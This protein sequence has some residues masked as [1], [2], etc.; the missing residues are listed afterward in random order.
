[1]S[2]SLW[3]GYDRHFVGTN[4]H[5]VMCGDLP[6]CSSKIEPVSLRKCPHL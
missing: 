3:S 6:C 1:M 2:P 4:I 5:E